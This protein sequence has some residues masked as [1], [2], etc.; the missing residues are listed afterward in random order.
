MMWRALVPIRLDGEV[1][2]RLAAILTAEQR[3]RLAKA[4]ANHVVKTLAA[5]PEVAAADW[6]DATGKGLNLDLAEA[7]TTGPTLMVHG[8][9]PLLTAD[10]AA[11]LLAAAVAAGAAIAPDRAG[12]GTNALALTEPA[13]FLAAFGPDSFARHRALLPHAAIVERRGLGLDVDTPEDLALAEAIAGPII[14]R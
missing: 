13:G 8:D 10:E 5:V 7:M 1:K 9:L 4:M 6:V 12:S 11:D 14:P 3:R 2:T